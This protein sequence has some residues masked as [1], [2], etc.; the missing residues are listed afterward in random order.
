MKKSVYK[1]EFVDAFKEMNREENFSYEGREALFDYLEEYEEET[2]EEVELDVI[3]LCCDYTEYESIEE[4]N[5]NY[6]KDCESIEDIRDYT[7]VIK[8]ND[9]K[10]IIQDF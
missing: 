5:N 3:A 7:Q 9:N 4:F 8:I 2:G 6:G 1:N 10:F